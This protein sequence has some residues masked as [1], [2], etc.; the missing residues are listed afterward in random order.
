MAELRG[1]KNGAVGA[2]TAQAGRDVAHCSVRSARGTALLSECTN[3]NIPR[4]KRVVA[5]FADA[6]L[7][8]YTKWPA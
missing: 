2:A 1:S 6:T 5:I 4:Q 3:R 7:P 8:I